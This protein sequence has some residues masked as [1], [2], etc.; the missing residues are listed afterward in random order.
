MALDTF[1]FPTENKVLAR[2]IRTHAL[3]EE[4]RLAF[5]ILTWNIAYA[6]LNG[7]RR[8]R[9]GHDMSQLQS[10]FMDEDGSIEFRGQELMSAADRVLA[11][12]ASMNVKPSV[13]RQDDSLQSIRERAVGQIIVDNL[14]S[15]DQL[16]NEVKTQFGHLFTW[17]GSCGL[18]GH[19]VDHPTLGLTGDLEVVHPRQL[20]PFPSLGTDYTKQRGVVRQRLLPLDYLQDVYGDKVG[21]QKNQK[22]MDLFTRQTGEVTEMGEADGVTSVGGLRSSSSRTRDPAAKGKDETRICLFREL[23]MDGPRGTCQFYAAASGDYLFDRVD[24]TGQET[25]C[26]IGFARFME[27]GSFHGAGM[28]DLMY[29]TSRELE[30]LLKALFTNVRDIDRYG[31]LV[32]P[33]GT[34]N[35]NAVLRDVGHGLKAVYYEADPTGGDVRPLSIQ[36]FNSGDLPGKVASFATELLDRINP[37]QDLIREKG[38]IDSRIGLEFLDEQVNRAMTN[39]TRGVVQAFGRAYR[40]MTARATRELVTSPRPLPVTRLSTELAGA[41]IDPQ[42]NTV[43]FPANPLPNVSR[44]MF[45]VVEVSPRS[46][47]VRKA[48]ALSN[49]KE[50]LFADP[51]E[52]KLFAV[53]EGLDVALWMERERGAYDSVV[54]NILLLYGDGE[55]N[56]A[57][58]VVPHEAAPDIQLMVL[59]A[60]MVGPMMSK[61]S[62]KVRNDFRDYREFLIQASGMVLPEAVPNPDDVALLTQPEQLAQLANQTGQPEAGPGVAQPQPQGAGAA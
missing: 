19:V 27:T 54:R 36:P 50:Q 56:Q 10:F 7:A 32:L 31:L 29:S 38:R 24:S 3:R 48:E 52:F 37:V 14:V 46:P 25:Y 57:I 11:R 40:A 15:E 49:V 47:A 2:L 41:V 21:L 9:F 4:T 62:P 39:P 43:S 20:L 30:R 53:K 6:W 28:F 60:F 33:H 26:P 17:L 18:Q 8:F 12:I 61:A 45:T 13:K 59:E 42:D 44:L 23:W 16:E 5:R 34:F 35:Q 58:T 1:K 51:L 55:N 22:L